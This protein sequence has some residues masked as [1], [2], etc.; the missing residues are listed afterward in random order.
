[1]TKWQ[2]LKIQL[3]N[4]QKNNNIESDYLSKDNNFYIFYIFFIYINY[5]FL[6]LKVLN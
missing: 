5:L 3:K 4:L 1:M 6:N 2:A